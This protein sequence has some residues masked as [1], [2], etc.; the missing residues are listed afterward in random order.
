MS[1]K[2]MSLI[3]ED[4]TGQ[5][6]STEKSIFLRMAD[7]A[8]D[9]GSSIYPGYTRI[10]KDTGFCY[11]TVK[12]S[13]WSLMKKGYLMKVKEENSYKGK[14]AVFQ[15]NTIKL[16]E[17][18]SASKSAKKPTRSPDA[19]VKGTMSPDAIDPVTRCHSTMSPRDHQPSYTSTTIT[20][21]ERDLKIKNLQEELKD[22]FPKDKLG[23]GDISS[24]TDVID[25]G[26]NPTDVIAAAKKY[27]HR[28][29]TT[30]NN[31]KYI[32]QLHKWLNDECWKDELES[33]TSYRQ[34]Y[35]Y[36]VKDLPWLRKMVGKSPY[37]CS[38][39]VE[40]LE[41]QVAVA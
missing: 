35:V 14:A 21:K 6:S 10:S 33:A 28:E 2:L 8:A 4:H 3:W 5:L 11:S 18:K 31:G 34:P 16:E 30:N 23:G 17:S 32:R 12:Q 24:I 20:Q 1:I 9:D 19:I 29:R 37:I 36:T 38:R 25:S 26:T 7:F 39:D 15:I 27:I 22:I 40:E 41:K 13:M